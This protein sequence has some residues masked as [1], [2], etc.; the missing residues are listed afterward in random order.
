MSAKPRVIRNVFK[1]GA[2]GRP[3]IA[4]DRR[5][6]IQMER[7]KA[8]T[9]KPCK[10]HLCPTHI[11]DMDEEY[12]KITYLSEGRRLGHQFIPLTRDYHFECVP[13]VAKPLV[14]FL[15]SRNP[16]QPA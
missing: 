15:V 14:R 11:I 9:P 12:A 2:D 16:E 7:I 6:M 10:Y 1:R 3:K 8:R 13:V 4:R 5:A